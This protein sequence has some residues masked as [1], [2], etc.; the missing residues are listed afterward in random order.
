MNY[1][2]VIAGLVIASACILTVTGCFSPSARSSQPRPYVV[3]DEGTGKWA[4][5]ID[6]MNGQP[7]FRAFGY[8]SAEAAL[9]AYQ[10]GRAQAVNPGVVSVPI[11][12]EGRF[13]WGWKG[14]RSEQSFA[15]P[16]A[17]R[18]NF[19][20]CREAILAHDDPLVINHFKL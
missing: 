7:I 11:D 16:Y 19:A 14:W 6:A 1:L 13:R 8:A 12:D 2:A 18:E 10:L 4:I 5:A 3:A 9:N 15:S 17:A 20:T